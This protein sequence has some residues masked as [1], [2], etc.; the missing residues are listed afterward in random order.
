MERELRT[1]QQEDQNSSKSNRK[2]SERQP[3]IDKAIETHRKVESYIKA[4]YIMDELVKSIGQPLMLVGD[5]GEHVWWGC[6]ASVSF[7]CRDAVLQHASSGAT[8]GSGWSGPRPRAPVVRE[9]SALLD[10]PLLV[11][12]RRLGEPTAVRP[13]SSDLLPDPPSGDKPGEE[14]SGV[15]AKARSM[16]LLR[17]RHHHHAPLKS[18][19]TRSTRPD[20][21]H[22]VKGEMPGLVAHSLFMWRHVM[23][24]YHHVEAVGT[25]SE[26]RAYVLSQVNSIET[27]VNNRIHTERNSF[28]SHGHLSRLGDRRD[29]PVFK[30][31][32]LL[33]VQ[34]LV[35]FMQDLGLCIVQIP[36]DHFYQTICS[37]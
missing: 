13:F 27:L 26:P 32:E 30:R 28:C 10:E 19:A 18:P 21:K 5:L 9:C 14:S 4:D 11:R 31:E 25:K 37:H 7:S 29:F 16:V 12:S 36:F 2:R 1:S 20:L 35:I 24:I 6:S 8:P 22:Q 15:P 17:P 23:S 33:F 3:E 34:V